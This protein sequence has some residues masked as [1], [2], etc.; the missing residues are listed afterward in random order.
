MLSFAKPFRTRSAERNNQTDADRRGRLVRAIEAEI[1]AIAAEHEGLRRRIQLDNAGAVAALD[2]SEFS[3]R[4]AAEEAEIA[5]ME[6]SARLASSRLQ[7]LDG[8]VQRLRALLP[9]VHALF[10]PAGAAGTPDATF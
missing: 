10:K 6:K 7:E 4:S 9:E 1:A 3:S 2:N 8:Q 5:Q